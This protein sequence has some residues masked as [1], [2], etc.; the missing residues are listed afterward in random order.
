M[1]AK[2]GPISAALEQKHQARS[3]ETGAMVVTQAH[4]SYFEAAKRGVV[5]TAHSQ[6]GCIWTV[7]LATTYTGVAVSNPLGSGKN[8][9]ILAAGFQEVVQPAG[10]QA[11]WLAGG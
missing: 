1:Y 6:T 10:I 8:L 7:G 2:V 11:A 5:F 4:G 3:E 9:S